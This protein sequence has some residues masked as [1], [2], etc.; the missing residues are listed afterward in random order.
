MNPYLGVLQ[1]NPRKSRFREVVN[2][3]LYDTV[4]GGK[5]RSGS[6]GGMNNEYDPLAAIYDRYWAREYHAAALP[7]V[8]KLLLSQLRSGASVLDICCGTGRFTAAV[9]DAG[10]RVAG[11]DASQEMLAY[12]RRNAPEVEFTWTDVRSFSLKAR[13]DAA[14]S[15]FESLNHVP[16]MGELSA[17][18]GRIRKHL[19]RG[20]PFLFDLNR[21]EAFLAQ[22]NETNAI[23]DEEYVCVTRSEYDEEQRR[24][25]CDVTV[26]G[27]E[28]KNWKR[29]DF[30]LR[31]TCHEIGAVQD[32]LSQSGFGDIALYDASD[33]GM[34]ED[35]GYARTFFLAA[36]K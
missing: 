22:W 1:G 16:D 14:C 32:A 19:K 6:E 25:A 5:R 36:A 34:D 23:V 4:N 35:T 17:A 31:Q 9:R 28:K 10:F 7:V 20:A 30:T 33:L 11:I 26:F 8:K 12:A 18:F 21:E 13:F 3:Y 15:V 29:S 2:I 27:R 24:A